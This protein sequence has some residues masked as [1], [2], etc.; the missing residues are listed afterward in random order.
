MGLEGIKY[1]IRDYQLSNKAFVA[2]WRALCICKNSENSLSWECL[3][4][5][6]VLAPN[7]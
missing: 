2:D 3:S 1:A 4:S 6:G 5:F 7:G